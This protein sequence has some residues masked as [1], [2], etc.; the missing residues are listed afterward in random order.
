[1]K[2]S[3]FS[4]KKREKTFVR[5]MPKREKKET[6]EADISPR[7]MKW[8]LRVVSAVSMDDPDRL[9]HLFTCKYADTLDFHDINSY[10]A[11][12]GH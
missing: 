7:L 12:H 6:M 10:S 4:Q 1:M 8:R 5:A 2:L 9:H 3:L 11:S